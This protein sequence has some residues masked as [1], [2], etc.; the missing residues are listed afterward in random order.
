MLSLFWYL[1][2]LQSNCHTETKTEFCAIIPNYVCS[3]FVNYFTVTMN[4]VLTKI[5]LH[6]KCIA[7]LPC[8]T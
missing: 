6:L 1:L 4:D 8:E 7:A 5:P 2:P 3:V